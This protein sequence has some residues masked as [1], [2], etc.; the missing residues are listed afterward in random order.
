MFVDK[1]SIEA[2]TTT[3]LNRIDDERIYIYRKFWNPRPKK[4]I[5][6][7]GQGWLYLRPC[8]SQNPPA[9]RCNGN[10]LRI[11][12]DVTVFLPPFCVVEWFIPVGNIEFEMIVGMPPPPPTIADHPVLVASNS[13]ALHFEVG[14]IFDDASSR[15]RVKVMGQLHSKVAKHVKDIL[16]ENYE[17]GILIN[18]AAKL[19][20]M[21]PNTVTRSFKRQYGL[22]PLTYL[23]RLRVIE[24]VRHLIG[25]ASVSEAAYQVGFGDLSHFHSLFKRQWQVSPS[26]FKSQTVAVK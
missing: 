11:S 4:E 20:H 22:S 16:T 5:D 17:S 26:V 19:I 25:G 2:G 10:L 14:K 24:S 6:V 9:L 21:P 12:R 1:K 15:Q 7:V 23:N 3:F 8:N 13:R 18:E